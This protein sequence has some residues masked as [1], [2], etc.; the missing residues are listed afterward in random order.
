MSFSFIKYIL[1]PGIIVLL[2]GSVLLAADDYPVVS[3]FMAINS[4][5]L[6]D[7]DG[8]YSDWIEIYNPTP[9]SVDLLNWSLTDNAGSPAK[10][11]FPQVMLA[12][13]S[14]MVIF[15]SG[16]D[17]TVTGENLHTNFRLSGSGEYL[18]LY[19]PD[20]INPVFS[21]GSEFPLQYEDV[22]YGEYGGNIIYLASPTPGAP[23]AG[24]EFLPPPPVNIQRGFYEQPLNVEISSPVA[25]S[26][27]Y[28]T[29][30]GNT[31]SQS[32]G[33]QY[34]GP[35]NISTTTPL[36]AV[37]T[38]NGCMPSSVI[39]HTYFFLDDVAGQSNDPPGYPSEWG[40]YIAP[41]LTG[42]AVADYEMDGQITGHPDYKDLL[43]PSLLSVPT[44]S[45]VT[46]ISNLF[47]SSTDP[48][49]G[50]IYMY[51]GADGTLG[52]GWERPVSFEYF[53]SDPEQRLQ[54]NCGIRIQ[55]GASRRPEKS[56]KHSFRLVFRS[57]YGP[58]RLNFRFFD[59]KGA[60]SELN[61]I[62]FRSAYG[63]TWRHFSYIQR[64]RA[65]HLRDPWSKDTQLDMGYIAVHNKFAHLYI[66][67]MY[68]GLY[69]ICER[70]DKDFMESYYGGDESEY[71]IIKD[72]VEVMDGNIVAWD[73][74]WNTV[75]NTDI[76]DNTVYQELIGN[77]PDGTP[78]E[79]YDSYLDP[80]SLIDYMLLNFY[81]G[82]NDWD[83]HN[84]VAARNRVKPDKGFQFYCWDTEKI[85]ENKYE[86]YVNENNDD[87][88]SG[89][90]QNLMK[91]SEFKLLFADRVNLYF[92]N[93]GALTP[94][95]AIERYMERA[96]EIE[97]AMIS[98]SARWGDYRRDVH[99]WSEGPFLL[100]TRND[101]WYEERDRLAGDYFRDRTQIVIDQLNDAGMLQP[102]DAPVFSQHGGDV[103][104]DFKLAITAPLGDIYY[105]RDG[106]DP[107]LVGGSISSGAILYTDSVIIGKI[108]PVSARAKDGNSWSAITSAIF[109][110]DYI[111]TRNTD[112][113]ASIT[114]VSVYPN[115]FITSATVGYNL[116]VSGDVNISVFSV[117]GLPVAEII[118]PGCNKG[119]NSF[120]WKPESMEPGVY[121]VRISCGRYSVNSKLL[122][123]R[124]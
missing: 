13:G 108:T 28:Y 38:K 55:G 79:D 87:R 52:D 7:E 32:S 47:S 40:D 92:Y 10:W 48:D 100:Y 42:N 57:E 59:D 62:I 104:A 8:D 18:A 5:V 88:P 116:P 77:N 119:E 20:S 117:D 26:V 35:V 12:P 89:I 120:V 111:T 39:T 44:I 49:S 94:E 70:Y 68:W 109:Y 83:H 56:P 24:G 27:I 17:R 46:D 82:N 51:T 115:P 45:L 34:T 107:R 95:A 97:Q 75:D 112:M 33:T 63:N 25:G 99:Q 101:Y 43:V 114:G 122:Y 110:N 58:G 66:N 65:Q 102:L 69:N 16:K 4:G 74:L 91:N 124:H 3:E 71:D 54:V 121:I 67:G 31:P 81:G 37:T 29:T 21:F 22:S 64:I 113:T 73:I 11:K 96:N 123:M 80:V 36:R 85:L 53:V 19:M 2:S 23:N 50:G 60:A 84:W 41:G 9:N 15:A 105:T 103:A 72:Y 93:G 6:Q 76:T 1:V 98:E 118:I 86:N 30:D 78:N 90:F 14:Y 61:T 106:T